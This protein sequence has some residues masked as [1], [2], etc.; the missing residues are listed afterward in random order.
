[1]K[2]KYK[3]WASLEVKAGLPQGTIYD[4]KGADCVR[5]QLDNPEVYGIK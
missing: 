3:E 5:H 1:M 2:K 4:Q